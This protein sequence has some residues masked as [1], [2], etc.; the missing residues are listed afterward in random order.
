VLDFRVIVVAA[1]WVPTICLCV[2]GD[3]ASAWS[4]LWHAVVVRLVILGICAEIEAFV[5]K[6]FRK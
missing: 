4:W 1:T 3:F 2:R 5:Q 6:V